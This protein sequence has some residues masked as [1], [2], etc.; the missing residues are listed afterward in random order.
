MNKIIK[1]GIFLFLTLIILN[2]I[3]YKMGIFNLISKYPTISTSIALVFVTFLLVIITTIYAIYTRKT[4]IHQVLIEIQKNFRTPEMRFAIKSLWDFHDKIEEELKNKLPENE[5][6]KKEDLKSEILNRFDIERYYQDE[7]IHKILDKEP[8]KG[9]SLIKTSFDVQRRR[10]SYFY[11]HL[12]CLISW[13]IL[14]K[15]YAEEFFSPS[16]RR[17]IRLVK[18][19]EKDIEKNK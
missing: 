6:L 17:T 5:K 16:D 11:S 4:M 19:L 12:Y 18:M 9:E 10:V 7:N 1:Y 2:L 13:N 3:F 15:N 8:I 14:P